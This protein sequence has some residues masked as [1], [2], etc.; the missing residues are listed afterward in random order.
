MFVSLASGA[1][2]TL[3]ILLAVLG[4]F[5]GAIALVPIGMVSI[6]A[7]GGLGLLERRFDS[8]P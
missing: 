2:V 1:L 7:G 5:N 3:G 8:R 4:L 6:V